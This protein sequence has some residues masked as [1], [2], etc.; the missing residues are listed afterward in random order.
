[1]K[2]G[3]AQRLL[4]Q[5]DAGHPRAAASH[6]LGEDAAAAADVQHVAAF[7]LRMLRDPLQAQR[8]DLVQRAELALGI[9]PAVREFPEFLQL[10]RIGVDHEPF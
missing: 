1:M 7:E 5:V 3:D 2:L 10:G 8:V 4:G 6:R 9:P